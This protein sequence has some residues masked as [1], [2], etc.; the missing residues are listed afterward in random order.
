MK[1]GFLEY[2]DYV[3]RSYTWTDRSGAPSDPL[4]MWG[5]G[6]RV[7]EVI[8][9]AL[10]GLIAPAC[11]MCLPYCAQCQMYLQ[12]RV[13]CLVP[14]G[15]KSREVDLDDTEA[16]QAYKAEMERASDEGDRILFRVEAC[17]EEGRSGE[18]GR[19]VQQLSENKQDTSGLTSHVEISLV[20]CPFCCEGHLEL[21]SR[22]RFEGERRQ[23]KLGKMELGAGFVRTL[24]LRS[25]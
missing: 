9:F 17:V 13:L 5:Y 18:L 7:L 3:S 10:G 2:F 23:V 20:S 8:G 22:T 4:G 1:V 16:V 21:V 19:L 15:I 12:S 6:L 11:L 24:S 14:M 25:H